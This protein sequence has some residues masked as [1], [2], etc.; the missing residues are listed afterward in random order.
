MKTLCIYYS[1]T[2]KTKAIMEDLAKT[3][4]A[5]LLPITDGKD[6]SG[7]RG[8]FG[9]AKSTRQETLNPVAE[10]FQDISAYD[11][12]ILGGPIWASTWC[13]ILES[14]LQT[15]GNALP[16][17]VSYVFTHMAPKGFP[18]VAANMDRYLTSPHE[19]LYDV[20]TLKPEVPTDR[21]AFL[22]KVQ[23]D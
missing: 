14:F 20:C 8:F 4:G 17:H 18:E 15:Y 7:I 1:R 19:A 22:S 23:A 16:Q 5:D 10:I 11:Q 9:A 2:G 3:I 13:S 21:A 6:W 12:V